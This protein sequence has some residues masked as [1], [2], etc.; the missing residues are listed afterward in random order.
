[1]LVIM[2]IVPATSWAFR[3]GHE[4]SQQ[5][6]E[7]EMRELRHPEQKRAREQQE[8]LEDIRDELEQIRIQQQ[9]QGNYGYP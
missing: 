9:L 1:M 8:V 6:E 7:R 5:I 3:Y 4:T 2:L